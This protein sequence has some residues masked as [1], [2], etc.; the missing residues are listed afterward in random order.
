M[1]ILFLS[2]NK[3]SWSSQFLETLPPIEVFVGLDAIRTSAED[4]P[5]LPTREQLQEWLSEHDRIEKETEIF[6]SG[7]LKK[8]RALTK[9][10]RFEL[11]SSM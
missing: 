4:I 5:G 11:M 3:G 2:L 1:T 6:D 10:T 8:L 7:E 9:G